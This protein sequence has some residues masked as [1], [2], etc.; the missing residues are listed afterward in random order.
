MTEEK[1]AEVPAES[2]GQEK[3]NDNSEEKTDLDI[4]IIRQV[5]YYFGESR[6]P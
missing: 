2:N 6:L 4:A 1:V 5:E 3:E